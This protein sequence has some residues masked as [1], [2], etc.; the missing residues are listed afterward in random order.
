MHSFN[1]IV[2]GNYSLFGA[3]E[4]NLGPKWDTLVKHSGW[5]RAKKDIPSKWVKKGQKYVATIC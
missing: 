4:K 1:A 2:I 5:R 3:S